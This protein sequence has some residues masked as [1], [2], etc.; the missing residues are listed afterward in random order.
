MKNRI[1]ILLFFIFSIQGIAQNLVTN[2]S[3]ET[4]DSCYGQPADIGFDV[5]EWSGCVGWSNPI[6]ASS[7]LWCENPTI[8]N[9]EPPQL[10][11][12]Y[13]YP[14]TGKKM[15]GILV[16]GGIIFNYREYIQNQLT[17]ELQNQAYYDISFY[18]SGNT[19]DCMLNQ[20]GV[21]FLNSP[22]HD[23]SL[24]WLTEIIPDAVNDV[25]QM[26]Y[27]TTGWQK[28]SMSYKA[29]GNEKFV[30]IGNFQDSLHMT[31][32]MPCDTIFWGNLTLA[33]GYYLIDDVEISLSKELPSLP[34]VL[35]PNGDG[36]NDFIWID[37]INC[38]DWQCFILN[39]WG[40]KIIVLDKNQ[41]IWVPDEE[42]TGTYYYYLSSDNCGNEQHGFIQLV[43]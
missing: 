5:F 43:R 9:I 17:Q 8:G 24:L 12:T 10:Y 6:G 21:K 3:F 26:V 33:G 42:T 4:I 38:E 18:I 14:R 25:S 30:I 36:I 23:T 22:L 1:Q 16:N 13:Q 35:T 11:L 15:A 41:P 19:Q 34:N 7:D 20:F 28:I 40:E 37:G 32:S 39:R 2:P 29:N 27:D 31:Y